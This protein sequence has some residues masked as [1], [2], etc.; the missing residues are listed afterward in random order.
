MLNVNGAAG[1][2]VSHFAAHRIAL[3]APFPP[4]NQYVRVTIGTGPQM[5]EFWRVWD[6][7]P[8]MPH[9]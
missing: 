6:L 8:P 2:V 5:Q 3:P 9:A 7:M 4:L 1:A